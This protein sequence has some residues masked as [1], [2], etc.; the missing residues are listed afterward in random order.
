[1]RNGFGSP[2]SL[3]VL[4]GTSD[5]AL[6]T[7]QALIGRGARR[8][9]LAGRDSDGLSAAA[10]ALRRAGAETVETL[11]FD[12]LARDEHPRFVE[13]VFDRHGDI[14]GVLLAFGLYGDPRECETDAAAALRVIET[15]FL[16]AVSVTVPLLVRL[17][18][19]GHGVLVVLSSVAAERARQTEF[20][21]AAS[22]AGLDAYFQGLGDGLVGSGVHVLVVRPGFVVTKMNAGRRAKPWAT[23]PDAVARAIVRGLERGS[24]TIWVPAPLR[25]AA[26]VMRHLPHAVFRRLAGAAQ[27]RGLD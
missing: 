4:G 27:R 1:M 17:R 5:I 21:Y 12:A 16:G 3:L 15:N 2:Q 9:L 23:K 18:D 20:V 19:Q 13:E 10:D 25:W 24:R 26:A 6:A 8:V 14:D 11:A 22:K 7:T